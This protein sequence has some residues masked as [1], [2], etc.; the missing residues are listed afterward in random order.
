MP[1]NTR[2]SQIQRSNEMALHRNLIDTIGSQKLLIKIIKK[3]QNI[4][5]NEG[6]IIVNLIKYFIEWKFSYYNVFY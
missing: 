4:I 2:E 3:K 6:E 5:Y 1:R